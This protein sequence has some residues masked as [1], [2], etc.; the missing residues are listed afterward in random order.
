M[1]FRQT[2]RK[3]WRL[4][5]PRLIASSLQHKFQLL[6]HS[7]RSLRFELNGETEEFVQKLLV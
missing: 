2:I 4:T 6:R 3:A 5:K 1:S 7:A